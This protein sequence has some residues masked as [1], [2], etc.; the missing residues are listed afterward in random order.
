MALKFHYD[1]EDDIFT[2]YEDKY[3]PVETIEFS[4]FFWVTKI[5]CFRFGGAKSL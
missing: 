3:P 4:D 1:E 2:L 5:F